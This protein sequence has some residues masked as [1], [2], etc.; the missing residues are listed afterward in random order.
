[1]KDWGKTNYCLSLQ[2]EHNAN[3]ILIHQF[4]Y[5]EK[6]L[7]RFNMNNAHSLCNPMVVQSIDPKH[8]L[9]RPKENDE[10]IFGPEVPYLNVIGA[11]LYA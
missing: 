9:F 5:V 11:L 6:I 1:M 3:E 2:I 10:E 4:A 7:K 8:D